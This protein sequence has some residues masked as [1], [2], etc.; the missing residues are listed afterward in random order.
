[1]LH[2]C[3]YA[4]AKVIDSALN[5]ALMTAGE[6]RK[7]LE[8]ADR[9]V[10]V[11]RRGL[12]DYAAAGE[13]RFDGLYM[14]VSSGRAVSQ[15]LHR[16][17]NQVEGYDEW[18]EP[19]RIMLSQGVFRALWDLRNDIEKR[20]E[21]AGQRVVRITYL[22][23]ATIRR[24]APPGALRAFFGD[25]MGRSGYVVL[26]PDGTEQTV[27]TAIPSDILSFSLITAKLPDGFE[28]GEAL[29]SYTDLLGSIVG[30]ARQRFDSE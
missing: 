6:T 2:G 25:E 11:M 3:H 29:V 17:R 19:H 26:M 27:Y 24:S 10:D 8:S 28:I 4:L 12:D 22:D 13:R 16:L 23:D 7:V 5:S 14:V 30:D 1:M 15:T 21:I 18:W 20:G 9:M